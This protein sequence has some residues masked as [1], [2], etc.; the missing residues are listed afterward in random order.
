M[1]TKGAPYHSGGGQQQQRRLHSST[2]DFRLRQQMELEQRKQNR[3]RDFADLGI[4]VSSPDD[5]PHP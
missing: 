4:T 2:P 1:Y 3:Q 5:Q